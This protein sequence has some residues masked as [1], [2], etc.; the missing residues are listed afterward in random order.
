[1]NHVTK[2]KE[3]A[4]KGSRKSKTFGGG[5]ISGSIGGH[6]PAQLYFQKIISSAPRN[7]L[8]QNVVAK[9]KEIAS[10]SIGITKKFGWERAYLRIKRWGRGGQLTAQLCL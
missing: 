9:Y 10:K 5:G 2:Y 8:K 6:L 1:M 7:K 3:F 4:S